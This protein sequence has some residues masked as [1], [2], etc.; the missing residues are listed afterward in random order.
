MFTLGV[1]RRT[2]GVIKKVRLRILRE[3]R[4]RGS[5]GKE[6]RRKVKGALKTYKKKGVEKKINI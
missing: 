1:E 3:E 5:G 2:V 4:G 6:N